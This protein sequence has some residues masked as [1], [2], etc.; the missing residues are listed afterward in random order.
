MPASRPAR[1]IVCVDDDTLIL[2]TLREQL[3]RGLGP[4]HEIELASSGAEALALL[5]ELA[6]E[7]AD[8][9]L[10]ISDHIMPGMKGT[11]LLVRLHALQPR[12]VKILLT[13]QADVDAVGHAVNAA[14]L[15][16]LLTKPWQETDLVLTVKEA[17][18]RVDQ[19]R[20]LAQHTDALALSHRQLEQSV[21]LLRATMDAT[22]DGLLVLDHGGAPVQI[23][24][25]LV[26][27]WGV[28]PALAH[29][30][31]GE[32]LLVHLRTR[33]K[34]PAAL[35]MDPLAVCEAPV[36]LDTQDGRAI[37]YVSRAHRV[38][39]EPVG[40]VCSFRDVTQRLRSAELI[41]HQAFHDRLSGLPNRYQFDEALAKAIVR[42]RA[43]GGRVSVL[44]VD[45]DHFKRINDSLGHDVGDELLKGVADRLAACLR[46]GDLIA[47]WGGDEFTVL[48]PGVH[49]AEE[50]VG[51]AERLLAAL[52]EPLALGDVS[53]QVSASIGMATFPDD[54]EDGQALLKRADMALYRVKAD[55][56]NGFQPFSDHPQAA[57]ERLALESALRGAI[58]RGELLLHYQPQVDTRTGAITHVE[59]LARWRHPKLGWIAP[60]VFIPI[61]EQTGLIVPLG[62]WVL[63]T[64]C[65]QA[66]RWHAEGHRELRVGVNLSA[67]QFDRSDLQAVV[68]SALA[69]TGVP[70]HALELEVTEAAALRHLDATS[71]TLQARLEAGVSVALDDFGT[72]YAS[73]SYLR[74]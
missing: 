26:E 45:L 28:P 41:R 73:L 34:D 63:H 35:V 36:V 25:Q 24:R 33:L 59:A 23:N 50:A 15:Y 1:T 6:A 19:E 42:A 27:L 30:A 46:E 43:T 49:H 5:E 40:I 70:A 60:D 52:A 22:L 29:P 3:L 64:A 62:E 65:A 2:R 54:G 9:P 37:E 31:A 61:A 57:D 10:V 58:E 38:R 12:M 4:G 39:G 74:Q 72:G 68:A 13:G 69:A 48:L 14:N 7:G 71:E 53:L 18:R 16:R 55:G 44:F 51:V 66:A 56:R 11:E 8:V 21:E 20:A 32:A 67:V 17:L 47:R